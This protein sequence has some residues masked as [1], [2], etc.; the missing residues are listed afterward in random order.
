[1][2]QLLLHGLRTSDYGR[3][4][5]L[6]KNKVLDHS[7]VNYTNPGTCSLPVMKKL[8]RGCGARIPSVPLEAEKLSGSG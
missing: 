7:L 6:E 1:M 4:L 8:A 5:E 2:W 3:N